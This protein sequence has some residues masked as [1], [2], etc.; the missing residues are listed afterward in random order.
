MEER[1]IRN[2][3]AITLKEQEWLYE[4][5][6]CIAGAGGL[7]GFVAEYLVRMG[8]G[9]FRIVDG[10]V[11]NETNI[12]RQLTSTSMN[13]G[14]SKAIELQE[15]LKS[16]NK[17]ISVVSFNEKLTEEN[18]K[19]IIGN[20][21]VVIDAFDHKESRILLEKKCEENNVPLVY[22]DV[23][24]DGGQVSTIYPNDK[25]LEKIF[26][27]NKDFRVKPSVMSMTVGII[28]GIQA[29]EVINLLLGRKT[30]KRKLLTID[31]NSYTLTKEDI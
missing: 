19:K 28:G 25:T 6:V 12:N 2:I 18:A 13:I 21:L 7:G 24:K 31:V 15:H 20:S 9:H 14:K 11:F 4:S 5:T 1:F 26:N 3:G 16:I 27:M 30:L 22:G 23:F 29:M 8:V 17:N 10:G